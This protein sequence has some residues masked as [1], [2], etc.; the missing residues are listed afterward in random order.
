MRTKT[1]ALNLRQSTKILL[2]AKQNKN[3]STVQKTILFCLLKT[4][5][6]SKVDF[7]QISV[8]KSILDGA[9]IPFYENL[10]YNDN[11]SGLDLCRL[12]LGA[13]ALPNLKDLNLKS[14]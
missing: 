8:I 13:I 1:S 9:D 11:I 7:E 10:V 4:N 2:S 5:I 3:P 6:P 14:K 12:P